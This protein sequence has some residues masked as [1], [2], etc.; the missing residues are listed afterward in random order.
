MLHDALRKLAAVFVLMCDVARGALSRARSHGVRSALIGVRARLTDFYIRQ[1]EKGARGSRVECPCC[2]WTGYDFYSM[3]GVFFYLPRVHCPACRGCERHRMLHLYLARRDRE[4]FS[5]IDRVLHVAPEREGNLR[6]LLE[7]AGHARV[8]AADGRFSVVAGQTR[9]FQCDAR[10]IPVQSNTFDTLFCLH[11]LEHIRDDCAAIAELCRV[12]KPGGIAYIMAPFVPGI[13]S[14][15]ALDKPDAIGH[16][17]MYAQRDFPERLA[18]FHVETIAPGSFLS[19]AEIRRHR[20]PDKEILYR[21]LKQA[22]HTGRESRSPGC[23][24]GIAPPP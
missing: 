22:A 5:R 14:S 8:F 17:W 11:V 16:V 7:Q 13:E 21:C 19:A 15:Y 12:L 2:G 23:G 4:F 3:D 9:A 10:H 20:V 1:R 18:C 24:S 6:A